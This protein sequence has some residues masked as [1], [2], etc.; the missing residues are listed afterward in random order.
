MNDYDK[1]LS[2]LSKEDIKKAKQSGGSSLLSKL[3]KNSL[4]AL[5][6][7][8][9]DKEKTQKILS[10]PEAKK[11]FELFKEEKSD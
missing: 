9:N 3:D 1:M 8:L 11:L 5:T 4:K 2:S 10:S 7:L 6:E